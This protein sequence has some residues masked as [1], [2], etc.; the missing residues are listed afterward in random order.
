MGIKKNLLYLLLLISSLV[1]AQQK[2]TEDVYISR[3]ATLKSPIDL[4]YNSTVKKYIDAYLD[5]PEKT[6]EIIGLSKVYFPMIERALRSKNIPLDMKYLAVAVSDLEPTAQNAAG[7]TGMWMMMYNVSRMYKLK[8]NSFIDE[9]KDPEKSSA[10]ASSHFRDLN[11][12]YKQWPL[13]IAAY[14][15]SPVM[16]NK[17]I[18][19][20]GNS[21]YF[22]DIYPYIPEASK[23]LYPKFIAAVYILNFY[24]EHG[25][26]PVFP[27][28]YTE[29]DSVRVNKWL[30]FQ[31]ISVTIDIPLDQLRKLNPVFKK[32]IIPYSLD[33][34]WIH[35]PQS[36][37]KQ[38]DLLKDS[39][40][41]PLPR[42]SEFSPIAIQQMPSDSVG[43]TSEKSPEKEE[44][45]STFNKKKLVY[46][47]KKG[48]VLPDIADWFD[49]S[50]KEIKSWNK[51]K[52]DKLKP[53]QKLTIWV[54]SS[55]TGYYK[56]ISTMTSK[57]KKQLKNKD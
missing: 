29:T 37:G 30:S 10:A 4:T 23:D 41:S 50:S 31:Q 49:V 25:I 7:A 47:V 1:K 42:P 11:S 51:L 52:S 55:K 53:G 32:D 14:G 33:G 13:V 44:K 43:Q 16:L 9:R 57:Q 3:L 8:V 56:R 40:Y 27:E 21:M 19:M 17:C 48:E 5:N 39:V 15:C 26:K 38:F 20:S 18:R 6:R 54:K 35:L 2:T 45:T 36:K 24:R 28:L 34:Y 22:W 46:A 12:I